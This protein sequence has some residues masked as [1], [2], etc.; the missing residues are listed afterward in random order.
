ML[1]NIH[2][3]IG[4]KNKKKLQEILEKKQ[5]KMLYLMF[6]EEIMIRNLQ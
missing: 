5:S 6:K 4:N 1:V 2:F 3:K